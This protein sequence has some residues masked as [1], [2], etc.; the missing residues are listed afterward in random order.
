MQ[1]DR[2]LNP[3]RWG[4]LKPGSRGRELR[5][6]YSETDQPA[7]IDDHNGDQVVGQDLQFLEA[8]G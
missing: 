5:P 1:T 4:R 3:G 6:A 2:D 8:Y 7:S